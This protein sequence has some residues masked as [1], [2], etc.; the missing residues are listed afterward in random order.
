M[1]VCVCTARLALIVMHCRECAVRALDDVVQFLMSEGGQ[2]A[3]S[4][5]E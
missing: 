5:V 3:V 1:C 2:A 4:V